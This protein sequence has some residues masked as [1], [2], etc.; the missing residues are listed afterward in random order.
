MG[1][2]ARMRL[3]VISGYRVSIGAVFSLMVLATTVPLG[4]FAAV[5][6][7]QWGAVYRLCQRWRR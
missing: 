1:K 2:G 3:D 5:T 4:L 6:R 7:T